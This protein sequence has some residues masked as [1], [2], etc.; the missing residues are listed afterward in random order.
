M[1]QKHKVFIETHGC[2]MNV[3]DTERAASNLIENG[4]KIVQNAADADVVIFNTCSIREKAENKVFSRIGEIKKDNVKG[5]IIGVIG[6]VAQLE[7]ALLLDKAREV[8]FVGG[9]GALNRLPILLTKALKTKKKQLDLKERVV[10]DWEAKYTMRHSQY[11]AYIPIIEGCNKFCTYCI[12]P[13]SRGR[14]RSR[15][16]KSILKEI[17]ELKEL[18]VKEV[19]LIG[20]N[21]NSYRPISI[22]GL[23]GIKGATPFSKLLRAVAEIGIPRIKFT[24][25]FPRDFHTDIV[26]A[27]EEYSNLCEWIHLPVQSGSDKILIAMR[28]G[29]T[30]SYY[31]K[32]YDRIC[33][34]HRKI[35]LTTDIIIGFPGESDN[36]FKE[37]MNL[38]SDC[39]FD[40]AYIFKYSER[41]GTPAEL[42]KDNV[43]D[44]VKKER[45][46]RLEALQKSF[47]RKKYADY[48]GR[49]V[50][51]LCEK[52]SSR[53]EGQ[54][55]GHSTCHKVV[56]FKGDAHVIGNI[57]KVVITEAK[58]NSL[59]GE[60][61]S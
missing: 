11:V 35:A 18:G 15:N 20:Q 5:P 43:D 54:L 14:E 25:S 26:S 22:E 12:V 55:T 48:I 10:E 30:K 49:T 56:N 42:L 58:E 47:Q 17:S 1:N 44:T 57:I 59:I 27:M 34:S 38:V 2:Q 52:F 4:Y 16:A 36:D 28:R 13:Y 8:S 3:S 50:E 40:G 61:K 29:Y 33:K 7:G 41:H 9:T 53:V 37:T 21:V 6:C 23:E 45:F 39:E 31:L 32:L 24:T 51:V 46:I 19:C 60:I